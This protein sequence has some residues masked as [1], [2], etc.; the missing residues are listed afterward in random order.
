[1]N[2]IRN[3]KDVL[4]TEL[5]NQPEIA[6]STYQ[7]LINSEQKFAN[8][9]AVQ[10]AAAVGRPDAH[11]GELPVA[12]VQLKPGKTIDEEALLAFAREHI[13]ERAAVPRH[14]HIIDEMPLTPV[15]KIF[16]PA[17][18]NKEICSALQEALSACGI[19]TLTCSAEDDKLKGIKVSVAL[20]QGSDTAQAQKVLGQFAF[21]I[22]LNAEKSSEV[23]HS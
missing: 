21:T 8:Q 6:A 1:M 4:T 23:H 22:K 17:L 13:S 5:T 18:K 12:Y 16:K 2:G 15:G 14:I 7:L 11:A 19:K 10:L 3:Q 9:P 20:A